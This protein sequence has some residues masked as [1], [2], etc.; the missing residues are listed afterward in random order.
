VATVVHIRVGR[1]HLDAAAADLDRWKARGLPEQLG[2]PMVALS[3]M[4]LAEARGD[5]DAAVAIGLRCWDATLRSGRTVWAL[6][7]GVDTARVAER[8]GHDEVVRRIAAESAALDVTQMPGQAPA[9]ELAAAMA[10]RDADRA[11]AAATAFS[12]RATSWA[13][14]GD[15]R[16]PRR[17]RPPAAGPTRPAPTPRG[18]PSCPPRSVR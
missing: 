11:A 2:L 10:A 6:H 18:A 4:L 9:A 14:C 15:G 3:E 17:R 5:L 13:S 12:L 1:G 8:S 7:A 16:K